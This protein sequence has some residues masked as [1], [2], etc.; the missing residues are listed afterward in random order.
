MHPT[1][2]IKEGWAG[3]L[4]GCDYAKIGISTVKIIINHAKNNNKP[5]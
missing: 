4:A 2:A 5:C 1:Q 3:W